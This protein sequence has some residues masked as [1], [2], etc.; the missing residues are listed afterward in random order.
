[1]MPIMTIP[2]K[3]TFLRDVEAFGVLEP[4][5]IYEGKVLDGWHRYQASLKVDRQCPTRAYDGNDPAGF[6]ISRNIERRHIS[7]SERAK[8]VA[9]IRKWKQDGRPAGRS[10]NPDRPRTNK[11]MAA[12]AG[13]SEAMIRRAKREIRVERGELPEPA[14]APRKPDVE[15][16]LPPEPADSQP[17]HEHQVT[18]EAERWK[19]EAESWKATAEHRLRM[20][21]DPNVREMAKDLGNARAEASLY[22]QRAMEWQQKHSDVV[23]DNRKLRRIVKKF[24]GI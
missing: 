1:M 12:E 21:D 16:S 15:I 22:Q 6:V 17:A 20:I 14:P 10:D 19:A 7:E 9:M 4:I 24:R 5:W 23:E 3:K 18:A 2:A 11:E 8:S 13:T